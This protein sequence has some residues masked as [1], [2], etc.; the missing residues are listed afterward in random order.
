INVNNLVI[1]NLKN[2]E[3][4]LFLVDCAFMAFLD[5]EGKI[6][7]TPIENCIQRHARN[8]ADEDRSFDRILEQLDAKLAAD[9]QK[10]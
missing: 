2:K 9:E 1:G 10:R 3:T 8:Q 7:P 5:S 4:Q 6:I